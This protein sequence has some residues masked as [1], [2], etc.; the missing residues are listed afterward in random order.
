[1]DIAITGIHRGQLRALDAAT[2]IS[3]DPGNVRAVVDLSLAKHQ[4]T[5]LAKVA[6]TA[7]DMVG[8][9]IDTLA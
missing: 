1:M 5:A 6:Q 4:T 7:D 8:S 2:A 3:R 9:L